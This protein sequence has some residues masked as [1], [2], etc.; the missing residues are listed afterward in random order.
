MFFFTNIYFSGTVSLLN[1][2]VAIVI[3]KLSFSKI[4][5]FHNAFNV[6]TLVDI[7]KTVRKRESF[8]SSSELEFDRQRQLGGLL[9]NYGHSKLWFWLL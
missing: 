2:L 6:R 7:T 8:S 3:G 5:V 9:I 1:C 4:D